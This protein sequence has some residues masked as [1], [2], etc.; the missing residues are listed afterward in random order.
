M[1]V[2]YKAETLNSTALLHSNFTS[3]ANTRRKKLRKDS[4]KKHMP[5]PLSIKITFVLSTKLMKQK[6]DK[7]LFA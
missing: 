5:H 3:R 1:G 7:F 2:V 6:M 4:S